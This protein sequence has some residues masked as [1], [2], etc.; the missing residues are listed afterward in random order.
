MEEII[1]L[2]KENFH[3]Q[4]NNKF[5]PHETCN[6]TSCANFIEAAHLPYYEFSGEQLE[7]SLYRFLQTDWAGKH[8][9]LNVYWYD[10][11]HHLQENIAMLSWAINIFSTNIYNDPVCKFIETNNETLINNIKNKKPVLILGDFIK[12]KKN[13]HFVTVIG[14]RGDTLLLADPYGNH[15][16]HYKEYYGYCTELPIK[17]L[18][19][20]W[21]GKNAIV[22]V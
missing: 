1:L 2:E 22:L 9:D 13:S 4:R 18:D 11:V 21:S 20:Y 17:Q 5:L 10:G 3:T 15:N 12:G 19:K 8:R 7:D 14:L 6:V 16:T